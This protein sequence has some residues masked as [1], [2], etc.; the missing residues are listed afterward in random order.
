MSNSA[1]LSNFRI[2][3]IVVAYNSG[4]LL[5]RCITSV[6][7]AAEI[8]NIDQEIVVVDNHPDRK[9]SSIDK[10][11]VQYLSLRSN[12]GFGAAN[13]LGF[14][15]FAS[16]SKKD[17]FFLINPDAFVGENFYVDFLRAM[18]NGSFVWNSPISPKICFSKT[19]LSGPAD[20]IVDF[21]DDEFIYLEDPFEIVALFNVKGDVR[22]GFSER[23]KKISRGDTIVVDMKEF[24]DLE[25]MKANSWL[26]SYECI[27][28]ECLVQDHLVQ[29]LGSAID[30]PFSAGDLNT[31]WLSSKFKSDVPSIRQAWCG[32][33]VLIPDSYIK[34]VGGF[35]E[36]YFLYYEDTDYSMRGASLGHYPFVI[37]S[38]EVLHEHSAST[39]LNLKERSITIWTSRSLFISQNF[40][41]LL[42]NSRA[43][44]MLA[45]A[46]RTL[47]LR[48][49]S[50]R[51]FYRILMAEVVYSFFGAI[52]GLGKRKVPLFNE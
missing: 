50:F 9:D 5:E 52:K 33:A 14:Q 35:D 18:N 38:L 21:G 11:G 20:V 24:K 32:A 3:V 42:A 4:E 22:I 47:L 34:K 45:K 26:A 16:N 1:R 30:A 46:I 51:H 19:Y 37:E 15:Y 39:N 6:K 23:I 49:T 13:N 41:F 36:K 8:A 31:Y 28:L 43:L 12:P 29:N 48:R 10:F 17:Y 25:S 44:V 27:N 2:G 7:R 40:G